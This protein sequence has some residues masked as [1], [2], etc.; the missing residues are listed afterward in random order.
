[1]LD[2][3]DILCRS[4]DSEVLVGVGAGDDDGD[5]LCRSCDSKG[6]GV[7]V[8]VGAGDDDWDILCRSCDFE[9][10][11]ILAG[12]RAT[13]LVARTAWNCGSSIVLA[14]ILGSEE[15][16]CPTE[17]D[18]YLSDLLKRNLVKSFSI[19]SMVMGRE[20]RRSSEHRVPL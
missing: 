1:M 5:T 9:G 16:R 20:K 7:L 4:C 13:E 10:M 17:P 11:G 12:A 18:G 15:E 8:G 14:R 2:D 3:G 19:A 6:M